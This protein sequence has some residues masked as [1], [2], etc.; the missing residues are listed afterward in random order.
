MSTDALPKLPTDVYEAELLRLQAEM[1]EMQ[2]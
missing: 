1:V 2:E